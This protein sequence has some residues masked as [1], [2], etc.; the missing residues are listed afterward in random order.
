MRQD[1]E[2]VQIELVQMGKAKQAKEEEFKG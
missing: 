1:N 2:H